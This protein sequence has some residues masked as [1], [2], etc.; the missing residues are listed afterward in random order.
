[1]PADRERILRGELP[2]G[3][4]WAFDEIHKSRAWRRFLKGLWDARPRGQRILVTGSARLDL[5]RHGGDS[6]QGRYHLLRLHPL[7]WPSSV[8]ARR[9]RGLF[10]LGV[11]RSR[12]S[13]APTSRPGVGPASIGR[14]WSARRSRA[15]S[16]SRTSARSRP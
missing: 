16:E 11:S 10:R 7:S 6:L 8:V 5:Y 12:S 13:A 2:A 14:G 9:P 3:R 1:M 15:S 4:L